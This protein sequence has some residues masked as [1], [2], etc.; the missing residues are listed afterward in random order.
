MKRPLPV[1]A[2][3]LI[4]CSLLLPAVIG[5]TSEG[6]NEYSEITKLNMTLQ[7]R[8]VE[9]NLE[10]IVNAPTTGWIAIGFDPSNK[11]KDAN[12]L[13]GYVKNGEV[14][15]RDDFGHTP[16]GHK[17]DEKLKGEDNILAKE[18]TER[19]GIT[20]LMFTIPLDSGDKYDKKLEP[21]KTYKVILAYGGNGKDTFT[22]YHSRNRTSVE[23]KI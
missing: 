21:G 11:M 8:V 10:V 5:F 18:G 19:E 12:I 15:L 3:S 13:I 4:I 23:I 14:F 1:A 17:S 16:T 7:W 2:K 20:E 9:E 22:V 6:E